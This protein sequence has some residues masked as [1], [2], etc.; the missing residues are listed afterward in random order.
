[1]ALSVQ[2]KAKRQNQVVRS[3]VSTKNPTH[4]KKPAKKELKGKEPTNSK[5][6]NCKWQHHASKGE[7]KYIQAQHVDGRM[8]FSCKRHT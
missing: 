7:R 5:Y 2:V 8:R 1:M 4:E 6:K 3:P